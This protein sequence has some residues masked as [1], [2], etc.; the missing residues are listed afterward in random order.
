MNK[1]DKEICE[2]IGIKNINEEEVSKEEV[3]GIYYHNYKELK[4]EVSG[5][6][7]LEAVKND[8]FTV[9]P[10]Y[11]DDKNI[12]N[13]RMAFRIKSGMVDKIKMNLRDHTKIISHVKNVGSERMK[14]NAMQRY[15][16]GGMN[17]E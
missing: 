15:V 6:K 2:K 1:E 17:R 9:L 11:M 7:K 13:S 4:I 12:E 8:D 16:Q 3:E 14:H 5:Y 10:D